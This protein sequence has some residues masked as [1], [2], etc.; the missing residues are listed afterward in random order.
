M[1]KIAIRNEG[2]TLVEVLVSTVIAVFMAIILLG[3]FLVGRNSWSTGAVY[4]DLQQQARRAMDAMV[5]ELAQTGIDLTQAVEVKI[6]PCSNSDNEP[7]EAICSG[8]MV[9]F[10]IP[11]STPEDIGYTIYKPDGTIKWGDKETSPLNPLEQAGTEGRT[12]NF[13]VAKP[14]S[15]DPSKTL[16]RRSWIQTGVGCFLAGTTILMADSTLRPIEQLK[17]GDEIMA[18]DEDSK[19]LVKDR[20]SKFFQHTADEYL[21]INHKIKLTANHPVYSNGKWLEIGVLKKGDALFNSEGKP[22]IIKDI[23]KIREKVKVY[24]I[25]VN[26]YHNYF[27]GGILAHN[28]PLP[29]EEIPRPP[30]EWCKLWDDFL[31]VKEAF[32]V[33]GG[34]GATYDITRKYLASDITEVNF[35]GFTSSGGST[36]TNPDL[37]EITVTAEKTALAGGNITLSLKSRVTLKN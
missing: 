32:A 19:A 13:Y 29:P 31:F 17:T 5:W 10:S 26:P 15:T 37:I 8:E 12:I 20:V 33:G 21:I 3:L 25:E 24:N 2:F 23:K 16:V 7:P 6:L 9:S 11:I 28:K 1:K 22:E 4:I 35:A 14:P 34:G 30:C 27:A 18:F 36:D